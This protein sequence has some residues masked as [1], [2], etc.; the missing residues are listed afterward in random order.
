MEQELECVP[1]LWKHSFMLTWSDSDD[2]PKQT[3]RVN[4]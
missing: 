3:L 1:P 2:S 4:R